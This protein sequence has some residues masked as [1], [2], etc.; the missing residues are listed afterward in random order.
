MRPS[1]FDIAILFLIGVF[2]FLGWRKGLV[3][4]GFRLLSHLASLALAWMLHP[5]LAAWLKETPFYESLFTSAAEQ[6]SLGT[7][8]TEGAGLFQQMLEKGTAAAGTAVAEYF[9]GLLVNG[10]SFFLI[11]FLARVALLFL[12]KVLHLVASLPILGFVN[13]LAG[14]A[15]GILEGLLIVCVLLAV[16]YIVPSLREN[17]PMSYAI[18]QSV[19]TRNLYQ[20]NPILQILMPEEDDS[21]KN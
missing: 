1:G 8:T 4:T 16:L 2:G 21:S 14:L 10:I 7:K 5:Y 11:L 19:L 18:E 13:R 9:A 17:K 6:A 15:V 12:G 20:S 3:K